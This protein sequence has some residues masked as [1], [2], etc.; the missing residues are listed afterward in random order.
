MVV[1][2]PFGS[3]PVGFADPAA[4]DSGSYLIV[5]GPD[6]RPIFGGGGQTLADGV[7]ADVLIFLAKLFV[8]ANPM[9]E[10]IALPIDFQNPARKL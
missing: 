8:I 1:V 4:G 6:V 5:S 2:R 3:V 7:L 10:K 9:V